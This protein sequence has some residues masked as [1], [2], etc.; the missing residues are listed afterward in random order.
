MRRAISAQRTAATA[1]MVSRVR[2][3]R[4]RR[5]DAT[6]GSI[7]HAVLVDNRAPTAR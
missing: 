7:N 4:L 3:G 6:V 5:V 2:L 1:R